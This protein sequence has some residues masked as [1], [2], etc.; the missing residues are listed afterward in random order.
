VGVGQ[1]RVLPWGDHKMWSLIAELFLTL[2]CV[3]DFV[4]RLGTS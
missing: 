3:V 1:K 4:I 2:S